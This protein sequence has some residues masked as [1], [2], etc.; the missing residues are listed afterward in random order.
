MGLRDVGEYRGRAAAEG[1]DR[2][3][4][5]SGGGGSVFVLCAAGLAKAAAVHWGR[6]AASD[7]R[8]VARAGD[9]PQSAILRF[10]PV[11]RARILSRL[12]LVL[13][14]QRAPAA[15]PQSALSA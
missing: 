14:H 13:L 6:A 9:A 2:G 7:C 12:L 1:A 8:A 15:L 3:A 11:Q 10:H 4:V 5:S